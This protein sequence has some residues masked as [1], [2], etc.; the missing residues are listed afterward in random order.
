MRLDGVVAPRRGRNVPFG[1]G[2]TD[3]DASGHGV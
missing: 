3:L 2:I 1:F